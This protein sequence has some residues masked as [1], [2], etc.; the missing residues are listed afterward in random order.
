VLAA[1]SGVTYKSKGGY[2]QVWSCKSDRTPHEQ[3]AHLDSLVREGTIFGLA[4]RGTGWI[5]WDLPM[6]KFVFVDE[7]YGGLP[8]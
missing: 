5:K 7:R 2:Y 6:E 8:K 1:C 3:R 4:L